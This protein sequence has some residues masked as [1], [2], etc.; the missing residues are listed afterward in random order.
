MQ[1]NVIGEIAGLGAACAWAIAAVL[2]RRLGSA[3]P[4]LALNLYKGVTAIAMLLMVLALQPAPWGT[5]N[6]WA[7]GLLIVS[8]V[9]GIGVG[10]TAF[11]ASLNRLGERRTV[12]MAETLAPPIATLIAFVALAE[13][14]PLASMVG[15]VITVSGVAWVVVERTAESKHQAAH[16]K[17]GIVY[18]LLAALC[19]AIGAVLSR[20]A[21]TQSE[22]GPLISSLIRIAGGVSVLLVWMPV[23]GR[24]YFPDSMQK[25]KPWR[26]VLLATFIGT[27][28]GIILQQLSLQNTQTGVA[29]T[30][31]ATS[32]LFILPMVA[33]NGETISLRACLGATIAITGIAMLF[34]AS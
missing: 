11:F 14:L 10:D 9:I 29:Q 3:I 16:L 4:P 18:G 33:I 34:L 23:T 15:I 1:T 7:L 28:L 20:A 25:R 32:S 24:V 27:F 19:Q 31:L 26:A 22:I 5:V 30:L 13:V 21:L 8:G 6:S 2:F 12:L 17:S